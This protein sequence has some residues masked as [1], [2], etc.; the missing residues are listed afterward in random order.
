[1]CFFFVVV[2]SFLTLSFAFTGGADEESEVT[3]AESGITLFGGGIIINRCYGGRVADGADE[4][5]AATDVD[6]SRCT[7]VND[8]AEDIGAGGVDMAGG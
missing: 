7:W 3:K 5:E 2:L 8:G 4:V 1:M 6:P